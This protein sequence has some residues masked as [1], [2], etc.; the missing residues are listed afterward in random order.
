[1]AVSC[2]KHRLKKYLGD[3]SGIK[4]TDLWWL[5][6]AGP[7]HNIQSIAYT[8]HVKDVDD[9]KTNIAVDGKS[10]P[11]GKDGTYTAETGTTN[12][13]VSF[14]DDS[15]VIVDGGGGLGFGNIKTFRGKKK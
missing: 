13:S 8:V 9:S 14:V 10:I 7:A 12:Y 1:L 5:D 2:K 4:T 11:V 6:S 15:L 3:Y